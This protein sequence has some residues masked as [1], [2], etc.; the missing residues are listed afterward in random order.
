MNMDI[1]DASM[2]FTAVIEGLNYLITNDVYFDFGLG[3][4]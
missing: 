3:V 2:S 4:A 1:F